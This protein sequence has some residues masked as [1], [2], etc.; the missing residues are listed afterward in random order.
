MRP[1]GGSGCE[2]SPGGGPKGP[3]PGRR[4][5]GHAVLQANNGNAL[6]GWTARNTNPERE[7]G[8]MVW[9]KS[10]RIVAGVPAVS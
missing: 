3:P 10:A 7:S 9:K 5:T 1:A 2:V 6:S 8:D 4:V